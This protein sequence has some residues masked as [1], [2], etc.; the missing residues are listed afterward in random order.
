MYSRSLNN[1][2]FVSR[3]PATRVIELLKGKR[4]VFSKPICPRN[5]NSLPAFVAL[6]FLITYLALIMTQ[7][8]MRVLNLYMFSVKHIN[9]RQKSQFLSLRIPLKDFCQQQ[10]HDLEI[11]CTTQFLCLLLLNYKTKNVRNLPWTVQVI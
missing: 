9:R 2:L 10:V 1:L 7:N 8:L 5:Y 3:L 11:T 6:W 4:K